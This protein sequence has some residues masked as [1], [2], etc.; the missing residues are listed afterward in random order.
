MKFMNV[1]EVEFFDILLKFPSSII[2]SRNQSPLNVRGTEAFC[3]A[4]SSLSC[5]KALLSH[6]AVLSQSQKGHLCLDTEF[7]TLECTENVS[8]LPPRM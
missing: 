7:V 8:L 2:L 1:A 3:T 5:S 4:S 6:S